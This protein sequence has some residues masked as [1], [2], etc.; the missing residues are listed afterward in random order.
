MFAYDVISELLQSSNSLNTSAIR[1]LAICSSVTMT[2]RK[3]CQH[4][5]L[6]QVLPALSVNCQIPGNL[7]II[8]RVFVSHFF[9]EILTQQLSLMLSS[10][11]IRH[12]HSLP[13]ESRPIQHSRQDGHDKARL[14]DAA[15]SSVLI[16]GERAA[17]SEV[18]WVWTRVFR[19]GHVAVSLVREAH[20]PKRQEDEVVDCADVSREET[21]RIQ[22]CASEE[23]EEAEYGDAKVGLCQSSD[24]VSSPSRDGLLML[25]LTF[26]ARGREPH[27]ALDGWRKSRCAG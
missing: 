6:S 21:G 23:N 22:E 10:S 3:E 9:I 13:Q 27:R 2:R 5:A 16:P 20:A 8:I 1:S 19:V 12:Q 26:A 18:P 14:C 25:L 11:F 15:V 24:T 17:A 4:W 7:V